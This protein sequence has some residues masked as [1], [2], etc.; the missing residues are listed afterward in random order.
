[1]S[2]HRLYFELITSKV[3]ILAQFFAA[4]GI[5]MAGNLL[6]GLLCV[7]LLPATEYA[8]FVVLFGVQGTLIVLMDINFSGTL[9]PLIGERVDNRQLIADYVA[10]LRQ[11]AHWIYVLIAI[12]AIVAYPLLVRNRGWSWR[13]IAA[14]VVILL[15]STWFMR[16]SAA[17]GAVLILLRDRAFWYRGQMISSLGTLVLLGIFWALGVLNG[18]VAIL[19]NVAGI[20]FVG[21]Y[22]HY[23]AQRLLGP[24][25]FG[26]AEKRR[27]I[28]K[29][30]LPN[31]PQSLLY[32]LQGQVSLFLI[33]YFG[34]ASGVASVGAL[35]RLGQMFALVSQMNPLLIEPYFAKLSRERLRA[36]YGMVLLI[37]G[38][39][40]ALV[41]LAAAQV[42]ELFLWLLG[43]QYKGLRI[44]VLI[45]ISTGAIGCLSGILWTIHSARRFVYWWTNTVRIILTFLLQILFVTRLD[46]STVRSVLWLNFVT[47]VG[48]LSVNVMAGIYGFL[49]GPREVESNQQDVSEA[50]I[51]ATAYLEQV[52][53]ADFGIPEPKPHQAANQAL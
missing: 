13:T 50:T 52:E 33:I 21:C 3:R 34:H 23:R 7:R 37:A 36:S 51:E 12:G 1:M 4:Q 10:S 35:S 30:A 28:V 29:L 40:C 48:S 5:T 9:V 38:G 43:P 41:T 15:V 31:I 20:V 11:L 8:K 42:P 45:S 53:S 26:S 14:M 2:R 22:Y 19:L 39:A 6:Y 25:G 16:V 32:A 17:Y 27:S 47:I 24:P 49:R 46:L 44:E 18:F